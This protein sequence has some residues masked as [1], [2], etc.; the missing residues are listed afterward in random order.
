MN[1]IRKKDYRIVCLSDEHTG[2]LVGLTPP[3]WQ[4]KF[5]SDT[6]S[7]HNKLTNIQ[8]ETWS[9]F[10]NT[11]NELKAEKPIDILV[12][13]GDLIDGDGRKSGG[14]EL[15][16][17]DR[18][19]QIDMAQEIIDLVDA[20]YT[21]IV[22]GT[23]YHTGDSEQFEEE[24]AKRNKFKFE[25]HCWLD[26]NKRIF[27]FKHYI[28]SSGTP[29]SRTSAVS[30]E[31]VWAS[32]WAQKGLVPGPVH[33]LVRSHVHYFACADDGDTVALTTPSL[34]GMGSRFGSQ[35]CSGLVRQ[36]FI[37]WDVF[38]N[39]EVIMNKHFFNIVSQK[40]KATIFN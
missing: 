37:S 9:I 17:T 26:V 34:Q 7:K 29:Q 6:V 4:G 11:I 18:T 35:K 15:L 39:G 12:N 22:A 1:I 30:K 5:V 27:D 38:A 21:V 33:Y 25:S 14:T 13:N 40:A 8:R 23:P 36:G 28:G 31:T 10:E 19:V 32:L 3:E 16:S 20:D 2:H 24:F